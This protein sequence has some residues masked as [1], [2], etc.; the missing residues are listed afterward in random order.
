MKLNYAE[1]VE[2]IIERKCQATGRI[3]GGAEIV[4]ALNEEQGQFGPSQLHLNR[5]QELEGFVL[6][7]VAC[8]I[9]RLNSDACFG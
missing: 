4:R 3:P 6:C 9:K 8:Q 2:S 7:I 5:Y 1:Q